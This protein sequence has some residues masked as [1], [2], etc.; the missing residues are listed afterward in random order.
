MANEL[1]ATYVLIQ[2]KYLNNFL[3]YSELEKKILWPLFCPQFSKQVL[4]EIACCESSLT[5]LTFNEQEIIQELTTETRNLVS[6]S[7]SLI[8]SYMDLGSADFFANLDNC[9]RLLIKL[10]ELS[11]KLVM[12]TASPLQTRNLIM[13]VL[14]V[15]NSFHECITT[16]N[17]E[18][19]TITKHAENLAN[20]LATLLRSLRIFSP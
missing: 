7:K 2:H 19:E 8:R 12:H 20:V 13:K 17:V 1:S 16:S 3:F 11:R 15:I 14:D 18:T 4:T 5:L 6:T 10:T 9:V